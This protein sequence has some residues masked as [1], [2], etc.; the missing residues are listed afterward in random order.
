M[1]SVITDKYELYHGD[2]LDVMQSLPE[3]SIDMILCDLPYQMTGCKWDTI[4]PF[5]KL[6]ESYKRV[7]K[8]N[9]AICLFGS[10]P[11]SALLVSSNFKA[12]KHDWMWYKNAGSNFGCVKYQPMREHESVFV[13]CYGKP[14]YNPIMQERAESG[15]KHQSKPIMSNVC[16]T[17]KDQ[18]GGIKTNKVSKHISNMRYPSS[19]QRFSR[20]R[21]LHPTQKPVA[22]CEYLIKTYSNENDVVLDNCMGSGSTGIACLN[23]NRNFIGIELDDKY[24][25]VAKNRIETHSYQKNLFQENK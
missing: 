15:W 18:Y 16:C 7:C 22:L 5:D 25:E 4:I 13:F 24:F 1:D 3:H 2:C 9:A 12:Y 23:T 19:V 11:F 14:I 17:D 20:E 8:K 10:M 21:G 6:W